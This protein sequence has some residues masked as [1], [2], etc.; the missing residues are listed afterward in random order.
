MRRCST[1]RGTGR[2]LV[3]WRATA[4]F[5]LCSSR[6]VFLEGV[7]IPLSLGESFGVCAAEIRR[8]L[9]FWLIIG[10]VGIPVVCKSC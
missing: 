5:D 2:S 1:H 7:L 8:W 4:L 6:V 9:S 3:V 10:H